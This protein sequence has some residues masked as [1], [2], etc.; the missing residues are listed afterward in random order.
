MAGAQEGP[1]DRGWAAQWPKGP[2]SLRPPTC[3]RSKCA[4]LSVCLDTHLALVLWLDEDPGH[5]RCPLSPPGHALAGWEVGDLDSVALS[6]PG[7]CTPGPIVK[8]PPRGESQDFPP[9]RPWDPHTPSAPLH[10][11]T[12]RDRACVCSGL[13]PASG[14][15]RGTCRPQGCSGRRGVQTD[16]AAGVGSPSP[17][18]DPSVKQF[19]Y[20]LAMFLPKPRC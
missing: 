13:P 14:W 12:S 5:P 7:A 17:E 3:G 20:R 9:A 15:V 10:K 1:L 8:T 18:E 16:P 2:W 19:T 4:G 11:G 6:V